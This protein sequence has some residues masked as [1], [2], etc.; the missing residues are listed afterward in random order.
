MT[1]QG[2]ADQPQDTVQDTVETTGEPSGAKGATELAAERAA[3]DAEV[4]RNLGRNFSA[5]MMH[6]LLGQTGF[7]LI[8]APTFIPA[9]IFELTGSTSLVGVAR[10][11]QALGMFLTPIVGATLIER[12]RKVMGMVFATGALMRIQVLALA[13]CG[14]F[15][16]AQANA[17]AVCVFLGLFGFFT[18]MQVVTFSFLVSKI[19][20][21]N[22]RGKLIGTRDALAG[23]TASGVGVLG[24]YLIGERF[25][26][27]GYAA[28]FLI[29]FCL[30]ALGLLSLLLVREPASL[31]VVSAQPFASRMRGVAGLVRR[32]R[33]F[34]AYLV[35]RGLGASG[36]MA[37]PYYIL[38]STEV[39]QLGP[40]D[41]GWITGAFLVSTAISTLLWGIAADRKGF[42]NTMALSLLAWIGAT[43]VLIS[44]E[45][46]G[47]TAVGFVALG[48]GM[49][50]FR[51]SA[52][53]LVLEFGNQEDRPMR[54]ALAQSA[55]NGIAIFAPLA[56]GLVAAQFGY[57]PV[58]WIAAGIQAISLATTV[59]SVGDPRQ[60]STQD[61][62]VASSR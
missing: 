58:F 9:Y 39:S 2:G 48:A 61:A 11:C 6:G 18:G 17:I 10:A 56:G 16:G 36:R 14:F 42:R 60:R 4:E 34:G 45:D 23:L 15:L 54:I 31:E 38:H 22:R 55:E 28:L 21:L 7:R 33:D 43:L 32:D 1:V 51:M 20:P 41:V 44:A 30:T 50:G 35:A 53:N 47:Q 57:L 19:I 49:G 59:L 5:H 29:A 12:R 52:M 62:A 46:F 27:N 40:S 13:L 8:H 3:F 37:V 26:G 25:L 24:G